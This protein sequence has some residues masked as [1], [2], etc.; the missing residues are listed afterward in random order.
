MTKAI[1]RRRS[2]R[3]RLL[4]DPVRAQRSAREGAGAGDRS[5]DDVPGQHGALR[6][7][8]ACDRRDDQSWS[9][10]W[11]AARFSQ[12]DPAKLTS[13]LGP[14]VEA[15]KRV[16][17]D[18]K[19]PLIDLD[20]SSRA[21][22]ERLGP[23]ET[24]RL[25]VKKDDGTWDT[26][27]LDAAGSRRLRPGSSSRTCA[28]RCRR[29]RRC[30]ATTLLSPSR[31]RRICRHRSR[32]WRERSSANP[33]SA[34]CRWAAS[35]PGRFDSNGTRGALAHNGRQLD[36][37]TLPPLVTSPAI[38]VAWDDVPIEPPP[39]AACGFAEARRRVFIRATSTRPEPA[40]RRSSR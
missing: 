36:F 7:R 32:C 15:V 2:R 22:C 38:I 25:N 3:R 29:S 20:A 34:P 14:W 5:G 12:T 24:A 28:A 39:G 13:T 4:P 10:P 31:S 21:L 9:R 37:G 8:G 16:A 23:V 26:T 33:R 18:K 35:T 40:R 17:A 11:S 27:H 6:R 1:G 19:V 30:C